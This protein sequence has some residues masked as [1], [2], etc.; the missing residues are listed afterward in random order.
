[1]LPL[2]G[3]GERDDL[4]RSLTMKPFHVALGNELRE[5]KLPGLLPMVSEP[6]EFLWIQTQLTGHLD[7]QIA[8]VKPPLGFRPGVEVGFRLL[9]VVSFPLPGA[10]S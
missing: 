2:C 6:A 5:R 9:H 10:W 1:M 8:Q 7:M 3:L 4:R